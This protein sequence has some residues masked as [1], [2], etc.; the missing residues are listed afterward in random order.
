MLADRPNFGE[1]AGMDF[2]AAGLLDGLEGE[3]RAARQRLLQRLADDGVGLA[4]LKASIEEDR[5]ALVP[6]ERVLGAQHTPSELERETG[7]PAELLLRIRRLSGLPAAGPNDPVLG[8][9]DISA[10][11]SIK[12]FLDSGFDAEAMGQ[13]TRILGEGMGRL[14]ATIT[15]AFAETFLEPGDSEDD[16]ATRFSTL[17]E[18]LTPA[19]T[20]V[21]VATFKAHLR[22]TVSRAV[23]NREERERGQ[24]AG[25]QQ[26]AVCFADL[27]G[28]TRLG[29]QLDVRELGTVA[30]RLAE[31]ANEVASPPVRLIKTIGDAA[32]FVSQ[33]I[34]P[35]VDAALALVEAAEAAELPALRAGVAS[36]PAQL[37]AGDYY[38]NSVNL[39]SRVTGIA[40]PR[41]VLCTKDVHDAAADQFAW[42]ST[43]RHRLKGISE[44]VA[45][46]RAR[47]LGDE[48][49]D[50]QPDSGARKRREDRRR[51]RASR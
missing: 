44:P 6:V 49:A 1:D 3:E 47:R 34:A 17:A 40:R 43:G 5:L 2:E 33:E 36:G 24:I 42:S 16:V 11:K 8:D 30:G 35:L 27:V 13:I 9:E 45:V 32:M 20:P 26:L 18:Q 50:E 48:A 39:A 25:E 15:A 29:G 21:L 12:V 31:L 14:A 38:G 51:R 4:E 28:F 37:R 7:V 10:A 23:L 41:S 22:E 46:Y 19:L